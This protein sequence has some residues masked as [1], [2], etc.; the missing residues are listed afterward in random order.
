MIL[1]LHVSLIITISSP[2]NLTL[3]HR[4]DAFV[5]NNIVLLCMDTIKP[6]Q[7]ETTQEA[8]SITR[9]VCSLSSLLSILGSFSLSFSILYSPLLLPAAAGVCGRCA[10]ADSRTCY[11]C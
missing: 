5:R 8:A 11:I 6:L 3:P 2:T 9:V 7:C 10:V 1:A 4:L